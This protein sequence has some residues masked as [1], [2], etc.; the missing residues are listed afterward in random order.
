MIQFKDEYAGRNL[1]KLQRDIH[2]LRGSYD[3]PEM[4]RVK[5][6]PVVKHCFKMKE[7]FEIYIGGGLATGCVGDYLMVGVDG[8]LYPCKAEIFEKSYDVIS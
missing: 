8:E 5:R 1:L 3:A 2:K 7:D 4:M 6:K